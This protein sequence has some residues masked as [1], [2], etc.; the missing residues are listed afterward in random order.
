MQRVSMDFIKTKLIYW[1]LAFALLAGSVA[2]A[3]VTADPIKTATAKRVDGRIRVDGHLNEQ[4]WQNAEALKSFTQQEPT[5]GAPPSESTLVRILYD[6]EA[7]Y[8]A[9]WCFD[10]EP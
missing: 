10:S 7:V 9:F 1:G 6:D 4:A 3:D 5:D 2:V 8:F